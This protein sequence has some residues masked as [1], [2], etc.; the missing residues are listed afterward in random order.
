M[1]CFVESAQ[2]LVGSEGGDVVVGMPWKSEKCWAAGGVPG[3]VLINRIIMR[4][5]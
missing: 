3:V 5:K 4:K 2:D 1:R